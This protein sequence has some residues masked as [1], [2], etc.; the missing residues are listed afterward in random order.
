[1]TG[2]YER[3]AYLFNL[4]SYLQVSLKRSL[5]YHKTIAV[6]QVN[7]VLRALHFDLI[8]R[9]VT[10]KSIC[11]G[12][13]IP[14][15]IERLPIYTSKEFTYWSGSSSHPG[16]KLKPSWGQATQKIAKSPG[17]GGSAL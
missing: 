17:P 13:F 2:D 3:N 9:K 5:L 14:K 12:I 7:I 16:A 11:S 6:S 1:M 10:I 8:C 4:H 15:Y